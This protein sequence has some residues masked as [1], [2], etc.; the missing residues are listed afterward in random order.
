MKQL[1]IKA[2]IGFL[3][4]VSLFFIFADCDNIVLFSLTKIVG[5]SLLFLTS[6]LFEHFDTENE[7]V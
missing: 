1:F 6:R 5:G 4:I 7:T 2:L 3:G